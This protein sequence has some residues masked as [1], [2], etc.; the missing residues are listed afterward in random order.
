MIYN[1]QVMEMSENNF[2][3]ESRWTLLLDIRL[4]KSGFH[5]FFIETSEVR[6]SESGVC[7]VSLITTKSSIE[8]TS[9]V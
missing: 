8:S 9:D 2:G 7:S 5:E 1:P 6:L 4:A 3:N